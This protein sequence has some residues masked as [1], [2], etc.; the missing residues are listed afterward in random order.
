MLQCIREWLFVFTQV[1]S[2][3]K[4]VASFCVRPLPGVHSVPAHCELQAHADVSCFS[5]ALFPRYPSRPL[6][7]TYLPFLELGK[8]VLG[9]QQLLCRWF[10]G[11]SRGIK[12]LHQCRPA[13]VHRDL[14][15]ENVM[16]T[17][18]DKYVSEAKVLDLGL[19]MRHAGRHVAATDMEGSFYGG[20]LYDAV[21]L[22]GSVSGGPAGLLHL[23]C[24]LPPILF[25]S[26]CGLCIPAPSTA[27]SWVIH[28]LT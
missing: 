8:V 5:S 25:C 7:A 19:H 24:P 26:V 11:I 17:S 12:Y 14:K 18:I 2:N 3:M 16:L 22:N 20:T 15:P 21:A 6:T 28:C 4:L 9:Q 10:V 1:D 27:G 13:I 23:R